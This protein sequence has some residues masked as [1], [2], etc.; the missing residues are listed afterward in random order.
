MICLSSQDIDS[1]SD[2]PNCI[3]PAETAQVSPTGVFIHATQVRT[4]SRRYPDR[5]RLLPQ[6]LRGLLNTLPMF[7]DHDLT[8]FLDE[9]ALL[10][11]GQ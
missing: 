1:S 8:V 5:T 3:D 6:L 10:R 7:I 11:G 9:G 2:K 4:A